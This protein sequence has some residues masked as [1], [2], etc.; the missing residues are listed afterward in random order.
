MIVLCIIVIG[1]ISL[2]RIKGIAWI[3]SK[4]M[5]IRSRVERL[6]RKAIIGLYKAGLL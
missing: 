3:T 2:Y 1:L 5:E 6:K 4:R